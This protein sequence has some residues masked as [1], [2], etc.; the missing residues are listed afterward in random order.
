MYNNAEDNK[1]LVRILFEIK[2]LMLQYFTAQ[3]GWLKLLASFTTMQ[4]H[5]LHSGNKIFLYNKQ[6]MWQI[7]KIIRYL[8]MYWYPHLQLKAFRYN[9]ARNYATNETRTVNWMITKKIAYLFYMVILYCAFILFLYSFTLWMFQGCVSSI[10]QKH[11]PANLF[12]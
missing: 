7:K 1:I 11:W 6:T 8:R 12:V 4:L 5:D 2:P 9:F 3:L 10:L